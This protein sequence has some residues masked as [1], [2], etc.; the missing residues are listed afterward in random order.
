M[1]TDRAGRVHL[2]WPTVTDE[3]G[4]P[5]KALFHAMTRDGLTFTSRV[6]LPVAGMAHHPQVAIARDD[7]LAVVWDESA[8]DGRHIAQA[9]GTVGADGRITFERAS[10]P[11]AA[12]RYP[13]VAAAGERLL[14]A[15]TSTAEAR[16]VIRVEGR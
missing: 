7:S 2:V 5:T 1:T 8:D 9:R 16:T 4:T 14:V 6:R 11:P 13:V 12:G 3:R 10:A 15:W